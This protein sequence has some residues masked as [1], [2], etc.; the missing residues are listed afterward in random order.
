MKDH[1]YQKQGLIDTRLQI[2]RSIL[3]FEKNIK[4]QLSIDYNNMEYIMA[5]LHLGC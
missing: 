5:N 2:R 4:I 3:I 1:L